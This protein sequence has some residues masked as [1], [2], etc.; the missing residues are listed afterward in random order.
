MA[1]T[2]VLPQLKDFLQM[3]PKLIGR[4]PGSKSCIVMALLWVVVQVLDLFSGV[5]QVKF[6]RNATCQHSN[7]EM[8]GFA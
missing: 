4:L 5:V 7:P 3:Y 2:T 6:I 8:Q 1:R